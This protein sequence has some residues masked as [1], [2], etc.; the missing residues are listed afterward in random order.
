MNIN[1]N[2][3]LQTQ[4]E[5]EKQPSAQEASMT[6]LDTS[7]T[8][9]IKTPSILNPEREQLKVIAAEFGEEGVKLLKE[10]LYPLAKTKLLFSAERIRLL[11]E[12]NISPR[13]S[14]I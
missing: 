13:N 3:K 8:Q 10:K 5:E 14:L 4:I 6:T 12:C 11:C 7:P 2:G 9:N 1:E